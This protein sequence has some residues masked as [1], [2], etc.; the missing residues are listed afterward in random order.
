M[1][2]LTEDAE[3][4]EDVAQRLASVLE[5]RVIELIPVPYGGDERAITIIR[6]PIDRFMAEKPA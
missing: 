4:Q 5:G 2:I 6:A 1:E 3:I